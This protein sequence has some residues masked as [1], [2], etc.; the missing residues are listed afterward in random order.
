MI[1]FFDQLSILSTLKIF[2]N[3][4][5]KFTRYQKIPTHSQYAGQ[6]RYFLKNQEKTFAEKVIVSIEIENKFM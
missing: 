6:I 1:K 4:A 5:I 2:T 3:I